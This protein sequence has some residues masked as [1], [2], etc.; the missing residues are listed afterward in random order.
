MPKDVYLKKILGSERLQRIK[1]SKIVMVGAGGIGCELLKDLLLSGFGEIHIVD[2]DT[3][4][5]S[6][7]NRQFLFRQKDIDK[8]K[9][10]TI[11]QAVQSFN[12]FDSNLVPHHG[13]VMD[14]NLFPLSWWSQF[15]YIYNALDN[16][17]ARRYVNKLALFLRKPLMESGTTGFEGQ[18]QPIYPYSTE[19]F[20]CQPKAT[21][22]TFPV[23]TIR[24]TPSQP[25]HCIVWAKEFLF[26]QLFDETL[27][28]E[29]NQ[30]ELSKETDD[31]EEI[32]RILLQANELSA[33]KKLVS[34]DDFPTKLVKKI[35]KDDVEKSLR[36][37]SL[38]KNRVPPNPLDFDKV[39]KKDLDELLSNP[40][41]A[42]L[43]TD[44][45]HDWSVLQNIYVLF[46][47]TEALQQRVKSG[48]QTII[49]FDKDDEDTLNFV[50]AAAN[51]R[52][53]VFHIPLKTKFDIKQ[54]AGNI[55][56]AIAT[57]NAI[58]SGLS[59][60]GS[61]LY[62]NSDFV[63]KD[64]KSV[65][66]SIKPNKRITSAAVEGPNP[67][68][69]SSG[70]TK[71]IIRLTKNDFKMTLAE[72]VK[73]VSAKYGY[74]GDISVILGKSR[75]IYDFDFDD[76]AEKQL[77]DIQGFA[78]DEVLLIQDEEE[79]LENLELYIQ[80]VQDNGGN[81]LPDVQLRAKVK[82]D[83]EPDSPSDE[84]ME[85]TTVVLDDEPPSKKRK[86]NGSVEDTLI[87]L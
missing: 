1:S 28:K 65:F 72:L 87:I 21:P 53:H 38:W 48:K 81:A 42:K 56:P 76:N 64:T 16:L 23:C 36:L 83:E 8:L 51:L 73:Q 24:S 19:C 82:F 63:A 34:D 11:A 74:S 31:P 47:S 37:E 12:F 18:I 84:E 44:D 13:N 4:T 86:T 54:I 10:L 2:L 67:K 27:E 22:Q 80:E 49:T 14:T 50:A 62:F 60:L 3:I 35:Y 75:L 77:Q 45:T 17:E 20:E 70:I 32:E 33:L 25:V 5:L 78:T 43:L 61:L 52:S 66:I 29:V 69:A 79:E 15:D 85:T 57:T 7:L 40:E 55:I 39:Y 26:T 46:K 6:N 9:S 59:N 71:A 68:C 30:A 58:I 41:N